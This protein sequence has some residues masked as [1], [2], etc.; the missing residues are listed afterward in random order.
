MK[1]I[2]IISIFIIYFY[3]KGGVKS[4]GYACTCHD[5]HRSPNS[6]TPPLLSI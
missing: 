5:P 6:F 4:L 2:I 1:N 3:C